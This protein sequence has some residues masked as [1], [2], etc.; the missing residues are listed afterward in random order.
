VSLLLL[1]ELC[2]RLPIVNLGKGPAQKK[3]QTTKASCSCNK[4]RKER[5]NLQRKKKRG[6]KNRWQVVNL[7]VEFARDI[8]KTGGR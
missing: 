7:Q 8:N 3:L 1:R 5:G 2:K 6:K 4:E